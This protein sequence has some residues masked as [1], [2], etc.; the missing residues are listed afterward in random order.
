MTIC[1]IDVVNVK[2]LDLNLLRVLDAILAEGNLTRAAQRLALSQPAMS[3]ALARLRAALDDPLFLRT[4]KG[5]APTPRAR[6]LA[7]PVRQ[8]L[9][10]LHNALRPDT[11]FDHGASSRAFAL[12]V[13]DYGEVVLMPRLADWL[14]QAAPGVQLRVR[15]ERGAALRD[16]LRT[17]GVDLAV[18]YF[19]VRDAE[20]HNRRLLDDELVSLVRHD[21]PALGEG[22]GISA[23]LYARLPHVVLDRRGGAGPVVD[24]MLRGAGLRRRIAVRVPHFLSMPLLVCASEMICTLP[25]R[26]AQVYAGHFGLRLLRPPLELPPVPVYLVWHRS[27]D[28]DPGQRWLRETILALAQRL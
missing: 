19:P 2:N 26:M 25:R 13:E 8:A 21:H 20:C 5:M 7:E 28:A 14:M 27:S 15:P 3:N 12:A 11:A 10:L 16:E 4:G 22:T 9:D 1:N 17:G 24:R 6:Q 18:D 23:E